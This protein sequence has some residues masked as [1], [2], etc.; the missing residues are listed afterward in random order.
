MILRVYSLLKYRMF[1]EKYTLD[2]TRI[3]KPSVS[4]QFHF[5]CDQQTVESIV[6]V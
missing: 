6:S 4:D 1:V 5:Y 3:I 2:L